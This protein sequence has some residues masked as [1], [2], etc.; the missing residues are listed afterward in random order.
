M[1]ILF[2][3]IIISSISFSQEKIMSWRLY[4]EYEKFRE[5]EIT[6]RRVKHNLIESLIK[7]YAKNPLFTVRE[8]GKSY[9]GRSIYLMKAGTGKIKVFLW[10]QMHGDEP[11]ANAALFDIFRLLTQP[12]E[13]SALRDTILN[14]LSLWFIPM[15]NPDGAERYI[16]ET[17]LGIDM[18]R[19]AVQLVTPEA[20]ILMNTFKEIRPDFGFNL[21]DQSIRHAAGFT[22]R[23]A[24]ISFLAPPFDYIK[25]MSKNRMRAVQ[26]I[27]QL[28]DILHQFIPGHIGK[29]SDDYEPRAFGDTFQGLGA[30]TILVESGGWPDDP[31]KQSIRKINF[32]TLLSAFS[33][34]AT[35][36][37]NKYSSAEY[38]NL[39]FNKRMLYNIILRNVKLNGA[40]TDIGI[41]HEEVNYD[42]AR[43]FYYRGVVKKTGKLNENIGITEYDL[44]GYEVKPGKVYDATAENIE[45]ID[46]RKLWSEGYLTVKTGNK[47]I[48]A[49]KFMKTGFNFTGSSALKQTP[50]ST[51]SEANFVLVRN[52]K[53][54]YI[55][56]NGFFINLKSDSGDLPNTLILQ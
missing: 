37:Y 48:L 15:L 49:R 20:N 43:T 23:Q 29:Y 28:T 7:N 33:S 21:H 56:L 9:E 14:N 13:F 55:I 30:S 34:I 2:F 24:T 46:K 19:D 38:D 16:R 11:T 35:G 26:V 18:N 50:V 40:V 53:V 44:S 10:A 42:N 1:K 45:A 12:G 5:P 17:A 27:S 8:L 6:H 3:L 41:D 22:P 52:G 36:S 51:D 54:D 47:E 4:Y 31:E 25:T 39:P 32:I